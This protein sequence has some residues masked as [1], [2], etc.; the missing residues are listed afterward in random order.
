VGQ[1]EWPGALTH[2]KQQSACRHVTPH[3][4]VSYSDSEPTNLWL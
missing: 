4:F 3:G 2:K 1:I